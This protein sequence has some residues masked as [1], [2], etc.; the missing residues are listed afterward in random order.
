MS[1]LQSQ[2]CLACEAGVK[3]LSPEESKKLLA[4]GR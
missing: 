1:N 3:P 2:R 4:E